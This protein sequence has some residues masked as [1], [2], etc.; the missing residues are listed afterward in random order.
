MALNDWRGSATFFPG[1][2]DPLPVD[3]LH[4]APFPLMAHR[5]ATTMNPAVGPDKATLPY[6]VPCMLKEAPL[7]AA[8]AAK[9]GQTTGKQ[10]SAPC[11]TA[12]SMLVLD[13]D[14][15]DQAAFD[16]LVDALK[17]ARLSFLIYSTHSHGKPDKP[18]IRARLVIPVDSPVDA[19]NYAAAWLGFDLIFCG[20]LIAAA[21]A[22]G[23]HLWQQQG[24]WA[25]SADRQ[26]KAFRLF[27]K[28]G[29]ASADALIAEDRKVCGPTTSPSLTRRQQGPSTVG[30]AENQ[31]IAAALTQ[32]DPNDYPGWIMAGQCLKA[33]EPYLGD[34]ARALWL[35]FSDRADDA[36][37]A[38]N[39]RSGT[40]P[41]AMFDRMHP[42]M[43]V[44]AAL[45]SLMA[46]AK[47]E[48]LSVAERE[49]KA[50]ALTVRGTSAVQHLACYHPA[51]LRE[52][53]AANGIEVKV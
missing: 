1:F 52:L 15:I 7:S 12:A 38:N 42:S 51:T 22:S 26:D 47:A 20:G 18:G 14:G 48:T 41:E 11:M 50:G 35:N 28:D 49:I 37:K 53:Y 40:D 34:E 19:A 27:H 44:G 10:R 9:T 30:P 31:K 17:A 39:N 25:T 8:M 4:D 33:L 3:D 32:I 24:V 23:R 21:D 2:F 29:V 5:L 16:D 45:G 43:P 36:S 6:F 13:V 46:V